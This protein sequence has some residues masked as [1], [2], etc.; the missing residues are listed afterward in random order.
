[1]EIHPLFLTESNE[2][3]NCDFPWECGFWGVRD[4]LGRNVFLETA[5]FTR[6]SSL[7]LVREEKISVAIRTEEKAARGRR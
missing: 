6:T 7:V 4:A 1:M 3:S 5:G 2:V